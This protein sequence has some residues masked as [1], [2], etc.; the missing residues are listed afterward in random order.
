MKAIL[1]LDLGTNTGWAL[2]LPDGRVQHGC[3]S[4]AL[5]P[6]EGEG[7]RFQKFRAFLGECKHRAGGELDFLIFEAKDFVRPNQVLSAQILFGLRGVMLGWCAAH[8]IEYDSKA[9]NTIKKQIAGNGHASKEDVIAAVRAR[10]EQFQYVTDH[11]EADAL[12]L[13]MIAEDMK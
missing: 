6:G 8:G 13:L 11:N 9:N 10:D 12:A 3:V 1:S 2:R 4:F 5:R 7:K